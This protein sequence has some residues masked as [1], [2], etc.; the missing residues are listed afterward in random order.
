MIF[1]SVAEL[2]LAWSAL[3]ISRTQVMFGL[4]NQH[5]Q[6]IDQWIENYRKQ[7]EAAE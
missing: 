3:N 2:E 1:P 5:Q 4:S 7:L 6:Q